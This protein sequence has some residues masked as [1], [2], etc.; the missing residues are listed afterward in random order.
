MRRVIYALMMVL[1][2]TSVVG[3]QAVNSRYGNRIWVSAESFHAKSAG[4]A[5][6]KVG[7]DGTAPAFTEIST[8]GVA[9]WAMTTADVISTYMPFPADRVNKKFPLA[10]RIWWVS[11]SADDD[12]GIDW[13]FAMEEKNLADEDAMEAAAAASLADKISFAADSTETQFGVNTTNWDTI[14]VT[15]LRDYSYDTMVEIS[16]ELDDVAQALG[17]VADEIHFIGL[18]FCS[19]PMDYKATSFSVSG[20]TQHA[21]AQGITLSQ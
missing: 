16:V 1:L 2:I 21:N 7:L 12:G 9:G 15:A 20:S 5:T 14:S 8:F 19:P 4:A 6:G 13:K 11:E 3:A 10:V 18:E 17:A